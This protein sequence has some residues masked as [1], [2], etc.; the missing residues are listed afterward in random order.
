MPLIRRGLLSAG[1][2]VFSEVAISSYALRASC[3]PMWMRRMSW[4]GPGV[5]RGWM[6]MV[7]IL[8]EFAAF[9]HFVSIHLKMA[10]LA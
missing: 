8:F 4:D 6:L 2:W 3:M 10:T 9:I 5:F 1:L 7:H